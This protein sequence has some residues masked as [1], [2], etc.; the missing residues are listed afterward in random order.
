LK[1]NITI[2]NI[3]N[4]YKNLIENDEINNENIN[5]YHLNSNSNQYYLKLYFEIKYI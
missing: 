4:H 1:K 5:L 2:K 3:V